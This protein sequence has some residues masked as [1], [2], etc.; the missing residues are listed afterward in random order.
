MSWGKILLV[1]YL[2]F[3]GV[4]LFMVVK[5]FQ[6]DF[7]MVNDD[8]YAAELKFQDQID[9]TANAVQFADSIIVDRVGETIHVQFPSAF[10]TA[11]TGE[12]YFYKASDADK[13]VKQPLQLDGKGTQQFNKSDFSKGFYTVKINWEKNNVK[14]YTEKELYL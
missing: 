8:Y 7:D 2:T 13:D 10:H 5:S 14:Y 12:L 4:M 9:A 6:Q 3:I 1:T 11:T